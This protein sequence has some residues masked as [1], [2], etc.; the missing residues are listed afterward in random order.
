MFTTTPE[1]VTQ[2]NSDVGGGGRSGGEHALLLTQEEQV[3]GPPP[4]AF[5]HQVLH[6]SSALGAHSA[7]GRRCS[8]GR[9]M[10]RLFSW[11]EG[12]SPDSGKHKH[13][14]ESEQRRFWGTVQSWVSK[15][16]SSSRCQPHS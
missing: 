3:V 4:G 2:Q 12:F 16:L 10:G 9:Q 1:Q 8:A 6:P 11:S 13:H 14:L 5:I 7:A 15:G